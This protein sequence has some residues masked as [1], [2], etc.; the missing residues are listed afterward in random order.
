MINAI[1]HVPA[2]AL[3]TKQYASPAIMI[4]LRYLHKDVI[5][6]VSIK[7]TNGEHGQQCPEYVP[8][9]NVGVFVNDCRRET[10]IELVEEQDAD[11]D[12]LLV[13]EIDTE[14]KLLINSKAAS[15]SNSHHTGVAHIGPMSM[16]KE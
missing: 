13:E 16:H 12:D 9:E 10:T 3:E 1:N 8:E 11:T 7:D 5:I 15:F 14:G 4:Q 2:E 6:N